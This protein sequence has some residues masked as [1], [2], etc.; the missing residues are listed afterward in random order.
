[1]VAVFDGRPTCNVSL[2][3]RGRLLLGRAAQGVAIN[4]ESASRE[5]AEISFERGKWTVKDLGSRNGTFVDG[6]RVEGEA[7]GDFRVL[8][9]GQVVLLLT[10]HA[11]SFNE[12]VEDSGG[13][14]SGPAMRKARARILAAAKEGRDLLLT[15]NSGTGKENAAKVFHQASGH[16]EGPFVPV[17]CATIATTVAE[18]LLFGA[19]KGA[20]SDAT[21]DAPGYFQ[22]AHKGVLFLDEMGELD[23]TAQPKLLRVL[24]TRE[25]LPVG[26]TRGQKVDL[27]IVMATHRDLKADT[28]SGRFR[29]DLYYRLSEPH[30]HLPTLSERPEEISWL[31]WSE[32]KRTA[33]ALSPNGKF[34]EACLMRPWPGNVRELIAETRRAAKMALE[35]GA[36]DVG[37]AHLSEQA[38]LSA[39][40]PEK[41]AAARSPDDVTKEQLQAALTNAAGSVTEAAK[42]LGLHRTQVYRLIKEHGIERPQ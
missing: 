16:A 17:N 35:A 21:Q 8:R 9:L 36:K 10:R 11:E 13:V 39:G 42:A 19:K 27:Q 31:I 15:G 33:A 37:V 26:A 41:T 6:Q 2:L 24:E 20:Y 29:E 1:V 7:S 30:V 5:H 3:I 25:V 34:I 32:T 23:A 40:E 14:V 12:G 28:A 38:G 22:A 18:R 4:D